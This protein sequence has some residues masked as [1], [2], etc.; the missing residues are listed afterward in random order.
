MSAVPGLAAQSLADRAAQLADEATRLR[1]ALL[2]A[3]SIPGCER[4]RFEL[5]G[6]AVALS[7]AADGFRVAE[8]LLLAHAVDDGEA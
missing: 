4:I 2:A 1:A 7:R 5:E 6:A 8:R 3:G